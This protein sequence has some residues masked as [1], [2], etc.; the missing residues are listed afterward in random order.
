MSEALWG[1]PEFP[2]VVGLTDVQALPDLPGDDVQAAAG[3]SRVQMSMPVAP[4]RR[5]AVTSLLSVQPSAPTPT[6]VSSLAEVDPA[7]PLSAWAMAERRNE[8]SL[9]RRS[10]IP[11]ATATCDICGDELPATFLR[12]AHVKQ[13]ALCA[14]DE[15][16][17]LTN[18]FVT[19]VLCDIAFERGWVALD[20]DQ[21]L[22][23]SQTLP[24]TP[25]L[26]QH[27]T[28]L[29][30]RQVDRPLNPRSIAFHRQHSFTP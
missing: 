26:Q 17:D 8:Q 19:C 29:D 15:K 1:S 10:L 21:R 2:W 25:A 7:A 13:R 30:G 9:L 23:V 27:L 3:F 14:D 20:D 6:A 5:S 18:V 4:E 28:A 11:G 24:A 22:I 16:R 12:A